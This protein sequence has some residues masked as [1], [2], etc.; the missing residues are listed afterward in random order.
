LLAGIE[1]DIRLDAR[2]I[3]PTIAWPLSTSSSWSVHSGFNQ[4]RQQMTD[5]LLRAIE[6]PHVDVLGHPTGPRS[7]AE[8]PTRWTWKPSSRLLSVSGWRWRSTVS[9]I[10]WDLNDVHARLARD[11]GVQ[12]V[13]SSDAHSKLGF[14]HLRWGSQFARRAWLEPVHVLNTLPFEELISRLRRHRA[15]S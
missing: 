4:E 6:H 12:I 8:T 10:G 15:R 3:S 14:P 7:F 5:R 2:S 13:I 11:H 1:C 9:R